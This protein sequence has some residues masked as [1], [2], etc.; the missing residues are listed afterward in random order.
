[1]SKIFLTILFFINSC[2]GTTDKALGSD[3]NVN[4]YYFLEE[5]KNKSFAI[6]SKC[7]LYNFLNYDDSSLTIIYHSAGAFEYKISKVSLEQEAKTIICNAEVANVGHIDTTVVL[8]LRFD[9]MTETMTRIIINKID[10]K[11]TNDTIYA[12]KERFIKHYKQLE[13]ECDKKVK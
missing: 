7:G 13:L 1:M 10:Y 3:D 4:K 11:E 6:T 8:K 12:T 5:Q 9:E 2:I